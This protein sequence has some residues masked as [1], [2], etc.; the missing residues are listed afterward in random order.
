M[1]RRRPVDWCL[2]RRRH[3]VVVWGVLARAP[4]F[5]FRCGVVVEAQMAL[6]GPTVGDLRSCDCGRKYC[7][8]NAAYLVKN[9]L[10]RVKLKDIAVDFIIE[11]VQSHNH[12]AFWGSIPPLPNILFVEKGIY[13]YMI[14]D[15]LE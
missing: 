9:H 1:R 15:E 6:E 5:A 8:E 13:T 2:W 11:Y 3:C 4:L 14:T 7:Q 10:R 12:S